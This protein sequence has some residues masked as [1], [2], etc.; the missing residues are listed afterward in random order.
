MVLLI[1]LNRREPLLIAFVIE[2]WSVK[3]CEQPIDFSIVVMPEVVGQKKIEFAIT[4][5]GEPTPP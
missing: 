3:A 5:L 2:I 1:M 4:R